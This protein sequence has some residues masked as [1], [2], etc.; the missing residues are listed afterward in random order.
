M[1]EYS[2]GKNVG[3]YCAPVI[4]LDPHRRSFINLEPLRGIHHGALSDDM[5]YFLNRVNGTKRV[6]LVSEVLRKF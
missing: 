2:V 6:T 1:A 3:P 4:D 5:Q